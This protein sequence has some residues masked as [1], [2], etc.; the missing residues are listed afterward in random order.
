LANCA[1]ALEP[2]SEPS[3][4]L[5]GAV[6]AEMEDFAGAET[7]FRRAQ[8]C[9]RWSADPWVNLGRLELR[10]NRFMEAVRYLQ[11]ALAMNGGNPT[12]RYQL[13]RAWWL[14]GRRAEAIRELEDLLLEAPTSVRFGATLAKARRGE[15]TAFD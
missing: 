1:V 6:L 4:N 14:A 11:R 15:A 12:T 3:W 13:A 2:G 10:R 5:R 8:V 7:A 9:D